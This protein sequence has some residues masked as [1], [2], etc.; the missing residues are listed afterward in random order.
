ML[1]DGQCL[2]DPWA[3][4]PG[5]LEDGLRAAPRPGAGEP[6]AAPPGRRAHEERAPAPPPR[7]LDRAV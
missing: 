5:A 6:E 1:N 7:A 2:D 3:P 4:D